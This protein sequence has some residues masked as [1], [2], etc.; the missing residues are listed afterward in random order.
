MS[1][2]ATCSNTNPF[3][4]LSCVQ[5][6][7]LINGACQADTS[8]S[9]DGSCIVCPAGFTLAADNTDIQIVQ[10]CTTCT[11]SS[12]CAR[13]MSAQPAV[14]TSCSY[15]MYLNGT[16]CSS[17]SDS[18]A[19]CINLAQ[20]TKCAAGF[21]D[22]Q[23]GTFQPSRLTVGFA[24]C[25]ACTSPCATCSGNVDTC[26]SCITGF[27]LSG[28]V[29]ISDFNFAINAVFAVTLATFQANYNSFLQQIADSAGVKIRNILI[30]SISSGSVVVNMQVTSL[31]PAGSAAAVASQ[32]N[33]NNLLTSG[34]I[35][36]MTVSS[37][38]LST[39]GGT[40]GGD[41]DGSGLSTT[42]IIILAVCIPG[43]VL[44][45]YVLI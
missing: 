8:C 37:F 1:P 7:N 31:N 20:C 35:A 19:S 36:G 13:C 3:S 24:N 4:C 28:D 11:S 18:C 30:K 17:C 23:P 45:K 39:N 9:T 22:Q 6:Y 42:T 2:C 15:G 43:G 34:N 40:N 10:T 38:T 25:V 5:G 41:D 21:V 16:V 26:S 29:C 44:C 33:L 27:T 12:N 14:C 32:N